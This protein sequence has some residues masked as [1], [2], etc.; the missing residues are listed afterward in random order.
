MNWRGNVREKWM[1]SGRCPSPPAPLPVGEGRT[2]NGNGVELQLD[3]VSKLSAGEAPPTFAKATA[4][5]PTGREIDVNRIA[6]EMPEDE[7]AR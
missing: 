5:K 7:L 1:S 3:C 2:A 6:E 4:D